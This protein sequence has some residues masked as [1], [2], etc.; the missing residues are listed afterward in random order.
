LAARRLSR[1]GLS[2]PKAQTFLA[3]HM[4]KVKQ[5][6]EADVL[7]T[8]ASAGAWFDAVKAADAR[9]AMPIGA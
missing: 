2:Y 7:P 4:A 5:R 6:S 9:A 8:Y 3:E 1:A